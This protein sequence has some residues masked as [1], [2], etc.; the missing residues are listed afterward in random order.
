MERQ[1][2]NLL[3]CDLVEDMRDSDA[4]IDLPDGLYGVLEAGS[5][6]LQMNVTELGRGVKWNLNLRRASESG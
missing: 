1:G 4:L 5:N 6:F 3:D 2:R